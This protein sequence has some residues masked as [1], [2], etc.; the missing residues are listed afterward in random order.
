MAKAYVYILKSRN[1]GKFYAGY[2]SNL[3]DRL[4]R[5]NR[6]ESISTKSRKKMDMVYWEEVENP[7]VACR[8]EKYI[9]DF[10][11]GRFIAKEAR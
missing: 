2:T 3:A 10:G 1:D 9:K 5:H 6:G 8:R 11:A 7:S 4:K